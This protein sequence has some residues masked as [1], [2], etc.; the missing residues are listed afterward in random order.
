MS[1]LLL[2]WLCATTAAAFPIE[3][4]QLG[5]TVPGFLSHLLPGSGTDSHRAA[6]AAPT[7]S[8]EE[9]TIGWFDPRP[10]G[11]RLLDV[12]GLHRVGS[13]SPTLP[14]RAVHDE[15]VWRAAECHHLRCIGPV[16]P[17]RRGLPCLRKVRCFIAYGMG[18]LLIALLDHLVTLKNVWVCTWGICTMLIWVTGTGARPSCSSRGSTTSPCGGRAGRALQVLLILVALIW[19]HADLMACRRA[20]FP[21]METE[22]NDGK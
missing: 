10:N 4:F 5:L 22:R 21:G 20:S 14:E 3:Y 18:A 16:R 13:S 7:R 8:A 12:S 19:M 2:F 9:E 1:R 15:E 11:G 6:A 17:H